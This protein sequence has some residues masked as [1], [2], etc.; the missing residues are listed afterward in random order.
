MGCKP[1][2]KETKQY[3]DR[4]FGHLFPDA[5]ASLAEEVRELRKEIAALRDDL[6]PV[7]SLILT[8]RDVI[9]EMKRLSSSK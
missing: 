7:P 8:G 5:E 2:N 6:T 4:Q 3:L 9:A 1:I